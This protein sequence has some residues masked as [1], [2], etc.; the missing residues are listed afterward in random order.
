M[1]DPT[2]DLKPTTE[3][4]PNG[5]P[6]RKRAANM[7]DAQDPVSPVAAGRRDA[8]RL[9]RALDHARMAARIADDNRAKNVLVLDMREQT[10]VVDYFVLAS[11]V[12]RRQAQSA[13]SEID[14]EMKKIG[15]FKLGMEG[16]E[17]GRWVLLDY[18][19][20]VVHVLA[21]EA[22][23]YYGLEEL[24]GDAKRIDWKTG[25]PIE[26]SP[27]PAPDPETTPNAPDK[28]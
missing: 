23:A 25:K 17:D 1:S 11:T 22:R 12:S 9:A 27:A 4:A 7:H 5:I 8:D 15:E 13:A 2:T 18:G 20:F 21:D 19:D 10:P 14:A 6:K 3:P 16:Y 24:W 26:E 28:G